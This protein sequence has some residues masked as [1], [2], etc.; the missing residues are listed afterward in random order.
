MKVQTIILATMIAQCQQQAAPCRM[1][2]LCAYRGNY[3]HRIERQTACV[4]GALAPDGAA[5]NWKGN[6]NTVYEFMGRK[7]FTELFLCSGATSCALEF[8]LA[9]QRI[10]DKEADT[11]DWEKNCVTR[12]HALDVAG[13]LTDELIAEA[14]ELLSNQGYGSWHS[15][16][17]KYAATWEV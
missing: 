15:M 6:V 12:L 5:C 9:C 11:A 4:L 13:E 2:G 16:A 1:G 17:A 3:D 7:A 8:F 14:G 10:H